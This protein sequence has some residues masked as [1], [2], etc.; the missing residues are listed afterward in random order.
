MEKIRLVALGKYDFEYRDVD[1]ISIF[2]H[3]RPINIPTQVTKIM[4]FYHLVPLKSNA[5]MD[6]NGNKTG[7]V[8]E[9]RV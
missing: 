9:N 7:T 6:L 5:L 8:E 4:V 2:C 3:F 1:T